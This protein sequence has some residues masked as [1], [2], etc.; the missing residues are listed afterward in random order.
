LREEHEKDKENANSHRNKFRK[1]CKKNLPFKP[2]I[3]KLNEKYNLSVIDN[4]TNIF[5]FHFQK[6]NVPFK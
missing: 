2:K 4:I 3:I 6:F 5:K 1:F